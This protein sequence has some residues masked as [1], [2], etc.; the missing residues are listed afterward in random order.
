MCVVFVCEVNW[1][2]DNSSNDF[3]Y[4][5]SLHFL[6]VL[7]SY[8]HPVYDS[9][10]ISVLMKVIEVAGLI[11]PQMHDKVIF[12]FKGVAGG[13]CD[14]TFLFQLFSRVKLNISRVF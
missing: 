8:L 6:F 11:Q 1:K 2:N 12:R 13:L 7:I 5:D 14:N 10:G 4:H 9:S 3:A